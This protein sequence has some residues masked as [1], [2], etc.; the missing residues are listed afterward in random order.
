MALAVSDII[1][2]LIALSKFTT[3]D[4]VED[5]LREAGDAVHGAIDEIR[6]TAPG[7]FSRQI[8]AT[9][10][11]PATV[12]ATIAAATRDQVSLSAT[13]PGAGCTVR[14]GGEPDMTLWDVSGS[15]AKLVPGYAA[16]ISGASAA[17]SA[18][19]YHDAYKV[20]DGGS[21]VAEMGTLVKVN[22]EELIRVGSREHAEEEYG[23]ESDDHRSVTTGTDRPRC[24]WLERRGTDTFVVVY[25]LPGRRMALE[26]DAVRGIAEVAQA[27]LTTSNEH[28]NLAEHYRRQLWLPL[29]KLRFSASPFFANEKMLPEVER[30]GSEA[31]RLLEDLKPKK[32]PMRPWNDKRR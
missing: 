11:A 32:R 12:T 28:F 30:Q 8:G 18:I 26:V 21:T 6:S 3:A 10:T 20:A 14:I 2:R 15:N 16:D 7:L 25:P 24:W 23:R 27:S 5:C 29:A 31:K 17:V 4:V 13:P 19:V 9:L 1:K 22:G